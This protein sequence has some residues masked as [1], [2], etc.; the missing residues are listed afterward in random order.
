M[1]KKTV[2]GIWEKYALRFN[3]SGRMIVALQDPAFSDYG[4]RSHKVKLVTCHQLCDRLPLESPI[5]SLFV[6]GEPVL[7]FFL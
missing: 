2:V 4:L 6:T 7:A 3:S 1:R 5:N